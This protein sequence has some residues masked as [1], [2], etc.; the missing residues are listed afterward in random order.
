MNTYP[1]YK[2]KEWTDWFCWWLLAC[3]SLFLANAFW[4]M[5][6]LYFWDPLVKAR[7][8]DQWKDWHNLKL[9]MIVMV[10]ISLLFVE[11]KWYLWICWF[12]LRWSSWEFWYHHH[13]L[14]QPY[15]PSGWAGGIFH[16]SENLALIISIGILFLPI[17][18]RILA[19]R[20]KSLP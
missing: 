17:I 14:S 12:G 8:I 7:I 1:F 19:S 10:V 5:H 9:A 6:D 13:S 3:I 15:E 20:F 18:P 11:N 16:L 2:E 4:T